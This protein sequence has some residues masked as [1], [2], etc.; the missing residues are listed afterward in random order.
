MVSRHFQSGAYEN[1]STTFE[2]Y[3]NIVEQWYNGIS[4]YS[5]WN[6]FPQKQHRAAQDARE[7]K[8]ERLRDRL[9]E[10]YAAG[11]MQV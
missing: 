1:V 8:R 11:S 6:G 4:I 10:R 3:F 9:G 2:I 7:T 5:I